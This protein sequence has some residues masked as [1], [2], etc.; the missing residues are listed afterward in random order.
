[1]TSTATYIH[2]PLR[3]LRFSQ[4]KGSVRGTQNTFLNIF[5]TTFKA[6]YGNE[7]CKKYDIC[8]K[9]IKEM[10]CLKWWNYNGLWDFKEVC[11]P[12]SLD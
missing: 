9:K 7:V 1:M 6:R 4:A 11:K 3:S 8:K 5:Q 12:G 2:F 10:T